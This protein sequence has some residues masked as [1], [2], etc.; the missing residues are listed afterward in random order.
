MTSVAFN[1]PRRR[2]K[3]PAAWRE[4]FATAT[5][6][7]F[8]QVASPIITLSKIT[9]SIRL[10]VSAALVIITWTAII[11]SPVRC[12]R[13]KAEVANLA[14]RLL[15]EALGSVSH[16]WSSTRE[17]LINVIHR[18]DVT[19]SDVIDHPDRILRVLDAVETNLAQVDNFE[20]SV[21]LQQRHQL[22]PHVTVAVLEV[23]WTN[24]VVNHVLVI[25]ALDEG[26]HLYRVATRKT[27]SKLTPAKRCIE[28]ELDDLPRQRDRRQGHERVHRRVRPHMVGP[29]RDP[30]SPHVRRIRQVV[31]HISN[32]RPARNVANKDKT[33]GRTLR[34]SNCRRS[35]PR[36]V[37]VALHVKSRQNVLTA[38]LRLERLTQR[39]WVCVELAIVARILIFSASRCGGRRLLVH[40][41]RLLGRTLELNRSALL[42]LTAL[43]H[44]ASLRRVGRFR[45]R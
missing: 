38:S 43:A 4:V 20:A 1:H 13:S 32:S 7:A 16:P 23:K 6:A 34:R 10:V 31:G 40:A 27:A 33:A 39:L 12:A 41:L 8:N 3:T 22:T 37:G 26:H 45:W 19:P 24:V 35:L 30:R 17:L 18:D 44:V 15:H 11:K 14:P 25:T 21:L 2:D 29:E 28:H 36:R 5:V 42:L 9:A